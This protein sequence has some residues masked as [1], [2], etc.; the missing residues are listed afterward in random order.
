M[1]I[2][3]A[4]PSYQTTLLQIC[5]KSKLAK[6]NSLPLEFFKLR[7]KTVR[8]F[9]CRDWPFDLRGGG[10][11]AVWVI[12]LKTLSCRL[13]SREKNLARKYLGKKISLIRI[14]LVL[15]DSCP[16]GVS[17]C[18]EKV[19]HRYMSGKKFYLQSKLQKLWAI[20][21]RVNFIFNFIEIANW[22]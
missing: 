14:R 2:K 13:F 9:L 1:G 19:L 10:G 22:G 8:L 20:A 17:W 7:R 3:P 11:G 15:F 4:G 12:C 6:V 18:W 16:H 21:G 5:C